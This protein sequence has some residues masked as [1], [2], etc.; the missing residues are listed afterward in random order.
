[1]RRKSHLLVFTLLFVF[2]GAALLSAC[3][4]TEGIGQDV[5]AAGDALAKSADDNKA[6]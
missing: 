2:G 3:N 6:Y 1:M 4:T 5:S